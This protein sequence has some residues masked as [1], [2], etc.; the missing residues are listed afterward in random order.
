MGEKQGNLNCRFININQQ[1]REGRGG[2]GS[3][4]G[5]KG[6]W[7]GIRRTG[8]ERLRGEPERLRNEIE[9]E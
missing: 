4:E 5:I 7:R 9:R 2:G 3:E 8:Q 6:N 1:C